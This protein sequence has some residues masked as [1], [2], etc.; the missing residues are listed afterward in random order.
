MAYVYSPD[1]EKW[2]SETFPSILHDFMKRELECYYRSLDTARDEVVQRVL[3]IISKNIDYE[4]FEH[5]RDEGYVMD[6]SSVHYCDAT[7]L[8][9]HEYDEA[10]VWDVPEEYYDLS[11]LCPNLREEIE[12]VVVEIQTEMMVEKIEAVTREAQQ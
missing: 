12:K 3:G 8:Y 11:V 2:K 1:M 4:V 6:E 9:R 7:G 10:N 5:F